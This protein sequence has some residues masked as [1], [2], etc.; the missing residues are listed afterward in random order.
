MK[1]KAFIFDLDGT[2]IDTEEIWE[3]A[4]KSLLDRRGIKL[5][6]S[7]KEEIEKKVRGLALHKSCKVIK[8]VAG[9]D[10]PIEEL[11]QETLQTANKLYIQGIKFIKGFL[12]FHNKLTTKNLRIGIATNADDQTVKITNDK[13]GL[14]NLFGEHI[15]NITCVNN[16]CKPAP[17]LYIFAA[18]KLN[19]KPSECVVI[20]DSE[21]GIRAAKSAGMFCIG[22]NTSNN[23]KNVEQADMIID[24]Y[25]E[26]DLDSILKKIQ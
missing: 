7:Q 15:Y 19:V 5:T 8:E 9:L 6:Q 24:G 18:Q 11:I 4:S 22:I 14:K 26:I 17:D 20:E 23:R 12:P 3:V 13:M 2:I 10:E 25:D 21:N 1:Y 16:I